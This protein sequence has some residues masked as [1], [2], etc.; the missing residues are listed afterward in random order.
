MKKIWIA[1]GVIVLIGGLVSF[2]IWKNLTEGSITAKVTTLS[3]ETIT[4]NVMTPG[5]LTL[6]EQQTI[7]YTPEKGEVAEIFVEEGENVKRGTPL[8]RYKNEQLALEKKQ[9]E[10][11]LQ[12][13]TLQLHDIREQHKELDEQLQEDEDNE[14]LQAEHDQVKLQ[15]QQANIEIKQAQLQQESTEQQIAELEAKS[16]IEG[17]VLEVNEEA[18]AGSNQMEQQP[19]VRIGSLDKLVVEGV[20]S[21]YDTLKIEEGQSVTLRSDA[22]PD[23]T[24]E[25][26]VSLVSYLPQEAD[27]VAGA[28]NTPG[29][30]YPIEVT[31]DDKNMN[32]KPG[33]QMILEIQTDQHK[34]KTLPLT[35]V[36]QD[37]DVH[38]VY[39][40][41]DGLAKRREVKVGSV[42]G[43]T[44]EM[45][46]GL[47]ADEQVIINPADDMTDGMEV[48]VT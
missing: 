11:Q 13:G 28:G 17:I 32:V 21:E 2:N 1:A 12:S 8:I 40:V 7:Y 29:V 48:T 36:K 39:V 10:L 15:Q 26:K 18:A 16:D 22:V 27:N 44:I 41:K 33:F 43:E 20:I 3:E 42:S 38:Y 25:G 4:E 14:Q 45:K 24:W 31:I 9:N 5:R 23:K 47:S 35:A 30:Q 6:A 46:D 34:A 19:L 37:G